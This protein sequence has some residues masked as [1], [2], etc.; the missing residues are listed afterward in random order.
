MNN[1]SKCGDRYCYH[2][3]IHSNNNYINPYYHYNNCLLRN[4]NKNFNNYHNNR[5]F[6]NN[7]GS[8]STDS[9]IKSLF[10]SPNVPAAIKHFP[11]SIDNL[12]YISSNI[13]SKHSPDTSSNPSI[14]SNLFSN[15]SPNHKSPTTK[16]SKIKS[17]HK[18]S[19]PQTSHHPSHPPTRAPVIS[20]HDVS[21]NI[22]V[23]NK[24]GCSSRQE[25]ILHDISGIFKPGMNAIMG[26]TGCG[27]TTLLDILADRK[28]KQ[29]TSGTILVDSL[30]QSN[31]FKSIAGYVVQDDLIM[32]TLTVRENLMFSADMRL[33]FE[34]SRN[35]KK[36]RVDRIIDQLGL[37]KCADT[38]V[39]TEFVRGVSGGERKRTCI[40][41]ELVVSPSIL[42]L[43]EPTTGLDASTANSVMSL[44]HRISMTGLTVIFSIHQPRYSIFK[45]FHTLMLLAQGQVIYHGPASLALEHFSMQNYQCEEHD[46]PPDFFLDVINGDL[47]PFQ[48]TSTNSSVSC[49]KSGV[50]DNLYENLKAMKKEKGSMWDEDSGVFE[51]GIGVV[52]KD[53]EKGGG[54]V[55]E[56]G[57]AKGGRGL[58]ESLVSFYQRSSAYLKINSELEHI[59]LTH[60]DPL[61]LKSSQQLQQ[62]KYVTSFFTQLFYVSQRTLKNVIRNPA[63]AIAQCLMMLV[64]GFIVGALYYKIS[65]D[66]VNAIQDRA[67]AFFFIIIIQMFGNLSAIELFIK[68]RKLFLHESKSGFYRVSVYFLSKVLFD[69]IPLRIFPLSIFCVISYFL[70]GLVSSSE[71]FFIFFLTLFLTTIIAAA[72]TFVISAFIG[73]LA[74]ANILVGLSYIIMTLFAGLLQ[75]VSSIPSWLNWLQY[76]SIVRYSFKALLINELS[77]A[78]YNIYA[79]NTIV[80]RDSQKSQEY[81]VS[82]QISTPT[83]PW[84]LWQNL[85]ALSFGTLFL[86]SLCYLQLRRLASRR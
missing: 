68:E 62:P 37:T 49:P 18:H 79:N 83:T 15:Q 31:N 85:A 35:E 23:T 5:D 76:F 46:N 27:K 17:S 9:S 74:I 48:D 45:L 11:L 43:D 36:E 53:A 70:M 42:F 7:Y 30:K 32:G 14:P 54:G 44:L 57:K 81:L 16:L 61:N 71:G 4:D 86:L 84:D 25:Q 39:G 51:G 52:E 10:S 65:D 2:N 34:V 24:T 3:H 82:Q 41:M 59:M 38:K 73:I 1:F 58:I 19:C 20:F 63:A 29:A 8:H 56:L 77:N 28:E 78:S 33:P 50:Q 60:K 55:E 6:Y 80:A 26:P 40:G 22:R 72:L 67:G 21:Y 47:T 12:S 75:N 69:L 64:F 13:S 66:A